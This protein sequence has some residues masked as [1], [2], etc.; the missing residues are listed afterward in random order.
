MADMRAE[1]F[2]KGHVIIAEGQR[3]TEA[4]VIE[5]G[6]VEVYRPG[7]PEL[8]LAVLGPGQI[9]GEMALVTEQPRSASVR[10]LEDVEVRSVGRDEFLTHLR[11]APEALLPFLRSLAERIRNLNGLVEELTS[12]STSTRDA[13]RAHLGAEAPGGG[14]AAAAKLRVRIEG[15]TPRATSV[16]PGRRPATID[17]FPYRI[18]RLALPE[19]PFSENELSIPDTSPWWVSRSHCA[20]AQVDD[21]CFLIDRG[22]RLGTLVD[23]KTLGGG[24]QPG[25]VELKPGAHEVRIG[26]ALTPFRFRFVVS[27]VE[28]RT[29]ARRTGGDK[30]AGRR[31]R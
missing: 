1:T 10:A 11:V 28:R 31:R 26:G 25:R 5:R 17:H 13:V 9:F 14:V 19:D 6:S 12:R 4:Y 30:P 15:L 27:S 29:T 24:R 21:R 8:P 7:P 16:L 22:S 20:L 23:G 3:G 18:G 2:Q